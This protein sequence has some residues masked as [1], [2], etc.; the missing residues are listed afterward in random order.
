MKYSRK[1]VLVPEEIMHLI[2]QRTDI[3]TS[4]LVKSMSSL[5][6]QMDTILN[7][8]NLP[9]EMKIKN[10]DQ[11]FQRYLNLQEQ[12]EN[13]IPTV[14]IHSSVVSQP[15]ESQ[16]Q[17]QQQQSKPQAIQ[18]SEILDTVPKRFKP[19]AQGLLRWMK[20]SPEAVQWDEKGEVSLEGKPIQGSSIAD[21]INDSL[22]TRKGFSP[23]G[24]DDFTEV[25]A[26]LNTPEDFVRNDNRRRLMTLLKAGGKLPPATPQ[27]QRSTIQPSPPTAPKKHAMS[28]AL[29]RTR[30]KLPSR[31]KKTLEW[32]NF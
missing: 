26:K 10:H 17:G 5:N 11:M 2:Q 25:L 3:Q 19:Q 14:Q 16:P 15:Q 21:L 20:K 30:A 32:I 31:G 12:R 24:R 8:T 4:P 1:M 22:R 27:V 9:P 7:D 29:Q 28:P 13:H 6:Q 23:A 18:D